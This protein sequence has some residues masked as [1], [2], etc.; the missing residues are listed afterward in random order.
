MSVSLTILVCVSFRTRLEVHS[1]N[2]IDDFSVSF[3]VDL[4]SFLSKSFDS[5]SSNSGSFASNLSLDK[6]FDDLTDL[7]DKVAG[8]APALNVSSSPQG[9]EKLFDI[10][11]EISAF[12]GAL[13]DFL[14]L[15]QNGKFICEVK[16]SR[17]L[18]IKS[19]RTCDCG[20]IVQIQLT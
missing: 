4:G 19:K 13:E 9:L 12:G 16:G 7:L 8:Y 6:L 5:V 1:E 18:G 17:D 10:V 11:S 14:A 2:V 3:D 20:H 15:V